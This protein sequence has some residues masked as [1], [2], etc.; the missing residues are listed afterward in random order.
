MTANP[1]LIVDDDDDD[2][3]TFTEA[4]RE[5]G[6]WKKIVSF[7]NGIEFLERLLAM[8]SVEYP[9][10]IL[11]D[12][13]MPK[14]DGKKVLQEIKRFKYLNNIP[15]VIFTTSSSEDDRRACYKLGAN[16]F[17]TKPVLYDEIV[18]A[19]KALILIYGLNEP[20][21]LSRITTTEADPG[22]NV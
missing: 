17:V 13:N 22:K 11:L 14:L 15:V 1:I 3:L 9:S 2:I 19:V 20:S 4:F 18:K 16:L 21:M 7:N 8:T 12:L 6:Y 5:A 10:L